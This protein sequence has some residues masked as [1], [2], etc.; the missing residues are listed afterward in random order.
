MNTLKESNLFSQ[1]IAD[2]INYELTEVDL[3]PTENNLSTTVTEEKKPNGYEDPAFSAEQ[4]SKSNGVI[5]T[6]RLQ[7]EK[8]VDDKNNEGFEKLSGK[9]NKFGLF[10]L[11]IRGFLVR[12]I[13]KQ[14]VESD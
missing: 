8:D 9:G 5:V 6:T 4:S 1:L 14:K 11:N 2:P 10:I 7:E 13:K 12:T 3:S